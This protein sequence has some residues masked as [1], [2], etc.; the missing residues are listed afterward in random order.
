MLRCRWRLKSPHTG[1]AVLPFHLEPAIQCC[2]DNVF[3]KANPEVCIT[4]V[5][6]TKNTCWCLFCLILN[7]FK[8]SWGLLRSLLRPP[9]GPW[10]PGWESLFGLF[11]KSVTRF[12]VSLQEADRGRRQSLIQHGEQSVSHGCERRNGQQ[13]FW[14]KQSRGQWSGELFRLREDAL[15][16]LNSQPQPSRV[17]GGVQP[18]TGC[19]DDGEEDGPH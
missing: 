14:G 3:L 12:A 9:S 5:P 4:L 17:P 18:W 15:Q 11:S 13:L 19:G 1:T 7:H 8:Y 6:S 16:Q 2:S 10:T